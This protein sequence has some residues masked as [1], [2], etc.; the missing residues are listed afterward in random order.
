MG[1]YA[2]FLKNGVRSRFQL[3]KEGR[4]TFRRMILFHNVTCALYI[5]ASF[6]KPRYIPSADSFDIA[7]HNLEA[8]KVKHG[9]SIKAHIEQNQGPFKEGVTGVG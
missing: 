7:N 9:N 4:K 2:L 5:F 8:L 3:P 1:L 6:R